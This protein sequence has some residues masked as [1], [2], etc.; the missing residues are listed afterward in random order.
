MPHFLRHSVD[1]LENVEC[2]QF[3]TFLAHP[4]IPIDARSDNGRIWHQIYMTHVPETAGV[5]NMELIYG[6]LPMC[7]GPN[8][9][10]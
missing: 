3:F 6:F 10:L 4:A 8:V 5:R 2:P 9:R 7:H 1:I